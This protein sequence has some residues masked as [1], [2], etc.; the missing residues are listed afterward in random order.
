MFK[1]INGTVFLFFFKTP[2]LQKAGAIV[3]SK[4]LSERVLAESAHIAHELAAHIM[5]NLNQLIC[6]LTFT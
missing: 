6:A 2:A 3:G 4:F 5:F 1:N